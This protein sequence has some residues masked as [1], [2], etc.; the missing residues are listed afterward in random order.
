M[1][2]K[3]NFSPKYLKYIK[4]PQ[5]FGKRQE[6]FAH[7]GR[8][9]KNCKS[10]NQLEVHH[11]SYRHLGYEPMKELMILCRKCH[12]AIHLVLDPPVDK[13]I[14][15]KKASTPRAIPEKLRLKIE[16]ARLKRQKESLKPKG[17]KHANHLNSIIEQKIEREKR[18]TSP[19]PNRIVEID[20]P[21]DD[22]DDENQQEND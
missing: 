22:V 4:S 20:V 3:K 18:L 2:I 19:Q 9:C 15:R 5:W 12:E 21:L 1:G 14:K 13:P 10:T 17:I 8:K 6:A 11:L 16:R 7:Y